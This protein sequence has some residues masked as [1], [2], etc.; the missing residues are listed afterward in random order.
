MLENAD[1]MCTVPIGMFPDSVADYLITK[2]TPGET[3]QME[4]EKELTSHLM[5][6]EPRKSAKKNMSQ[7][8]SEEKE[9][10]DEK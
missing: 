10:G 1:M 5:K 2:Y 9:E 6:I 4:L 3:T 8:T 7:V